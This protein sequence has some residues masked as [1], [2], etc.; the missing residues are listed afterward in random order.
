MSNRNQWDPSTFLFDCLCWDHDCNH[1]S[2][3][4]PAKISAAIQRTPEKLHSC[5]CTHPRTYSASVHRIFALLV[6]PQTFMTAAARA[7]VT[8]DQILHTISTLNRSSAA[9]LSSQGNGCSMCRF[10][11]D[12][13]GK[14]SCDLPRKAKEN[15][16]FLTREVNWRCE[17]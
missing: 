8:P 15:Y 4:E 6:L 14:K 11:E 16:P 7:L 5:S 1:T 2:T 17:K 9:G 13:K 10:L 12:M 3:R